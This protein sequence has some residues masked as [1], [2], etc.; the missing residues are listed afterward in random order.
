[1]GHTYLIHLSKRLTQTLSAAEYDFIGIGYIHPMQLPGFAVG[2]AK[3][4]AAVIGAHL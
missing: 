1:M 4:Q 3:H 2:F